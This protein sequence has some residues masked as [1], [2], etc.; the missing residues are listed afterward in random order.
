MQ[1]I[2]TVCSVQQLKNTNWTA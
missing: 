2:Q 1:G